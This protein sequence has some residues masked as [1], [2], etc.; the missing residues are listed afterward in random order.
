MDLETYFDN[1]QIGFFQQFIFNKKNQTYSESNWK[2]TTH[3][4]NSSKNTR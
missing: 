4:L 3:I 2:H 1:R